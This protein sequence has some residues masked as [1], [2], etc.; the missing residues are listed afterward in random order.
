MHRGESGRSSGCVHGGDYTTCP[1]AAG[2]LGAGEGNA[3][4]GRAPRRAGR[5][6]RPIGAAGKWDEM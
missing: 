1:E 6:V 4:S 3:A 5:P 2:L